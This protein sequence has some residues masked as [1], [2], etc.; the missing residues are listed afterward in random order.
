VT[1]NGLDGTPVD[2][3][4]NDLRLGVNT[5]FQ[6]CRTCGETKYCQGHFGRIELEKAVFHVGF[7]PT[8][9]KVL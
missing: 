3:G 2:N 9:V 4:L 1:T 6:K 8:V 7:L 5:N